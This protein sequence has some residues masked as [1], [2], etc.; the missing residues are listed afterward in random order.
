MIWLERCVE[1][2]LLLA[3]RMSS[4]CG[5]D[6]RESLVTTRRP[7]NLAGALLASTVIMPTPK[8]RLHHSGSAGILS[9]PLSYTLTARCQT[10]RDGTVAV[11]AEHT[12]D[13]GRQTQRRKGGGRGHSSK[14]AT[15]SC[16]PTPTPA[17]WLVLRW[18]HSNRACTCP[19]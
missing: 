10:Q 9:S 2:L 16:S 1:S 17:Y 3:R 7:S 4:R 11:V 5:E 6:S 14:Q 15:Q 8:S 13:V 19:A 12:L 18:S